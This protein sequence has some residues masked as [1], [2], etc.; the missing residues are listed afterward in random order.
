ML[1]DWPDGC[2]CCVNGADAAR[3]PPPSRPDTYAAVAA[4][5]HL[6]LNQEQAG[7]TDQP[8]KLFLCRLGLDGFQLFDEQ[9]VLD[10][11]D[12]AHGFVLPRACLIA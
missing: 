11:P 5:V 2:E 6:V 12:I 3:K 9:P 4:R 1:V 10:M 7:G 8:Y